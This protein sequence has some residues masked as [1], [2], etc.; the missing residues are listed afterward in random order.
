MKITIYVEH[1]FAS[2]DADEYILT[3]TVSENKIFLVTYKSDQTSWM[4][5]YLTLE[6]LNLDNELIDLWKWLARGMTGMPLDCIK[7]GLAQNASPVK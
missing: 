2:L 3:I 7:K 4:K 6:E 5:K 1:Q